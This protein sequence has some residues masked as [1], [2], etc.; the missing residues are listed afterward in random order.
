MLRGIGSHLAQANH[1][2]TRQADDVVSPKQIVA[3]VTCKD[4][5]TILEG[6]LAKGQSPR[7]FIISKVILR[8]SPQALPKSATPLNTLA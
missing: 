4:R 3:S 5:T 6:V 8:L 1:R 2:P 7:S